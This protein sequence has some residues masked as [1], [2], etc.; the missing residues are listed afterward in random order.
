MAPWHSA[1]EVVVKKA[2]TGK[3]NVENDEDEENTEH[4]SQLVK[5]V[6]KKAKKET[7]RIFVRTDGGQ[8]HELDM[9][10]NATIRDLKGKLC[11]EHG[12]LPV[13]HRLLD[14]IGIP[15]EDNLAFH[16]CGVKSGCTLQLEEELQRVRRKPSKNTTTLDLLRAS[17]LP[18]KQENAA[19][20]PSAFGVRP[21]EEEL[22]EPVNKSSTKSAL[23]SGRTYHVKEPFAVQKGRREARKPTQQK[24]TASHVDKDSAKQSSQLDLAAM[25][26]VVVENMFPDLLLRCNPSLAKK[27]SWVVA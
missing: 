9:E 8:T 5:N 20:T 14:A 18:E 10:I 13:N 19:S 15:L 26:F 21:S 25:M 2:K 1:Y 16:H 23:T 3:L 4:G 27:P 11:H 24:A 17:A 12:Y 6:A 7:I 22:V